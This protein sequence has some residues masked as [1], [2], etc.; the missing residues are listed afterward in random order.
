[1]LASTLSVSF[2]GL[3]AADVEDIVDHYGNQLG[4]FTP[5]GLPTELWSGVADPADYTL[6]GYLWR[7]AEP[8]SIEDLP[9]GGHNVELVLESVPP[10]GATI[11][12]LN[13]RI[14]FAFTSRCAWPG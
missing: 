11:A 10:E 9:C 7:Y 3:P 12:G 14:T 1:M 6:T 4:T 5:F 13:R 2:I 8:P